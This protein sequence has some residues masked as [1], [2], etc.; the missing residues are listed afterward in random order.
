MS[1]AAQNK[2]GLPFNILTDIPSAAEIHR[3]T[4]QVCA[5]LP[6][7]ETIFEI[8]EK[9][10]HTTPNG[11]NVLLGFRD[12]TIPQAEL[13]LFLL[14][15]IKPILSI[16]T[17][18][19]KGI[20]AALM[21]AAHMVNGLKGGHVPM[22]NA[23]KIIHGGSGYK[24][25][26][27]LGLEGYQIMEHDPSWVLPQVFMERL[28][29]GLKFVYFNSARSFDEQM[30]EYFYISR[31]LNEGGV[32]AI[33]T[34]EEARRKLVDYIRAAH[35]DWAVREIDETLTL[36]QMPQMSVLAQHNPQVRH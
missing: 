28:N 33:N 27:E 12:V 17:G 30:M 16:E 31:M 4:R 11:V 7:M 29:D 20:V 18:F 5:K 14:T 25:M 10:K 15:H 36:V 1:N 8:I 2:D 32:I 19:E 34:R 35:Q 3:N 23:A 21:T 6:A 26:Q 9:R 13:F 24:L 22:Q